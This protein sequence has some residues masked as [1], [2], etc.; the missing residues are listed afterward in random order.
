MVKKKRQRASGNNESRINSSPRKIITTTKKS[1]FRIVGIGASAGGLEALEQFFKAM[2]SDSGMAFVIVQHL[3]PSGHSSMSEILTRFTKMP[4]RLA[5]D[6][7]QVEANSIYLIPSNKNMGILRG[8]I[9]LAELARLPGLRLPIDFFFRALAKEKA[10]DAIGIVFSGTGTD[11][12]L[13]IRAIKAEMG[14]VFA[15]DP[16]SAR[17]DGMPRSA[18]DTGLVDFVLKP[19]DMPNKLI[20]FVEHLEINGTESGKTSAEDK[21]PLHQI[22]AI[23]RTKTGHDFSRYKRPT[24]RRRLQRR[25]SVN[26]IS[27]ISSYARFLRENEDEANSLLKDLLISVTGFFRDPEAF[28][29]LKRHLKALLNSKS[30]GADFRIWVAGC[31]T[32]EETY[33][34]AIIVL[35]C[36]DELKKQL[37]VQ[38][39]GTDIDIDTLQIARTGL[40]P[41]NIAADVTPERLHAFFVKEKNSFRVKK[42][43]REIVVFAPQNIIKDPPFSRMD[44]I[45][46]RNLLIYLESD[47]QKRLLPLF[48]YALKPGA[49]LFLGPSETIGEATDLFTSLDRKWKLFRR[50]EVA[51]SPDRLRFPATFAPSTR[52]PVYGMAQ[53]IN[54]QLLPTLTEKIF[55]DNYAPTFAIIDEKYRLVYVR[56]RTGKYLEIASGEPNW[57]IIEMARE[58]LRTDLGSAIYKAA[59]DKKKIVREG[60]RVKT[61]GDFLNLNLTVVPITEPGLPAGLLMVVFQEAGAVVKEPRVTGAKQRK[62]ASGLEDEL[63]ITR[64]KLQNTI[65]ELQASNEELKSANE[66]LQSNNEELQS[67]NE[68]LDTSREE[69]QS[70]NEELTTVNAELQ[71]KNEQL[72]KANDDLKNFLNRTD[73][74]IIFVDEQ[75]KIRSF[76]P[77]TTDIFNIRDIDIGRPFNEIT[78]RLAYENGA[79][80]AHEVLRTLTPKEIEVERRDGHWYTMRILPYFTVQNAIGG[81]VISFLDIDKQKKA[82]SQLQLL[83]TVVT[84]SNDA[85]T[86][87][88]LEGNILTWNKGAELMYG[89]TEEEARKMTSISLVADED[90]SL[91]LQFLNDIRQGKQAHSLEVRRQTKDG[92]IIDVWLTTTKL[93]DEQ[94]KIRVATTERDITERKKTERL[95]D[96][97]IGMVSHEMRT[98]LTVVTAAVRTALDE[99]C[100]QE[101]VHELLKEADLNSALLAG[102]LDNLLELSRLQ[103]ER[104][105]LD[106][107]S[108]RIPAVVKKVTQRVRR[109][110]PKSNL[111]LDIESKLPVANVDPVRLELV[112][113]NLVDN[114]VKYSPEG[115]QIRVFAAK[116][117]NEIVVGVKDKG[118]GLTADEQKKLFEPFNRFSDS[119]SKA[120][121]LGLGL[122]VCQR[123]VEA[124]GG[125]IWAESKPGKGSTFKF[126]IP[127]KK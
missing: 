125:R 30:E 46:C 112:I 87:Q 81:L 21:E 107:K 104:I 39:Y 123:L 126:T 117:N 63:K 12:T 14:T 119:Y 86:T 98:P 24:V 53:E 122:V 100:T 85:I 50:L 95:K 33:S 103:A 8:T 11:G 34:I 77:A 66:E 90:R 83:A 82:A 35:E 110:H 1:D 44:L 84:D 70:L 113:Y 16:D 15:Q 18:I 105:V 22:F 120:R 121:G 97:F 93:M 91:A 106:K 61:N 49:I 124:Q 92:G 23:L 9:F 78:S 118:K 36:L 60:I 72:I 31:A 5:T 94:G 3:D 6:G 54:Q 10:H 56:G 59:A 88:D 29:S 47:L 79:E 114:A 75:Y 111:I 37:E 57:T 48:H 51:V 96:E 4:V 20:E 101:D 67:T 45:C 62:Y 80:D 26:Q 38:I 13:G 27:D 41:A 64:E 102:I 73:I 32:G 69:L 99:R 42:E 109:L 108:V 2:P 40:Y 17:Y 76:T 74:A 55:L 19:G 52:Q 25:M 116:E 127:L 7:M 43:I 58:G 68:E 65:E 89:Y 71:D 28:V 115:T